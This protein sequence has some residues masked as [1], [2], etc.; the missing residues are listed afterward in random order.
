MT[1]KKL[2]NGLL[3]SL[4]QS[5]AN[6]ELRK[7]VNAQSL[8]DIKNIELNESQRKALGDA[9]TLEAIIAFND[10]ADKV[11]SECNEA[12]KKI[13]LLRSFVGKL[14]A[15][16]ILFN[17]RN[18]TNFHVGELHAKLIEKLSSQKTTP[19]FLSEVLIKPS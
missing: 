10:R 17:F 2:S 19:N 15:T 7:A 18:Y 11:I 13:V 8:I 1:E 9:P 4:N 16:E 3:T 6:L 5:I 12:I 14:P